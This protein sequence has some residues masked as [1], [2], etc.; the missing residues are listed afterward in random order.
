MNEVIK[1]EIAFDES[2]MMLSYLYCLDKN[3]KLYV[4]NNLYNY[5]HFDN[6]VPDINVKLNILN[7]IHLTILSL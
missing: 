5:R 3:K 4:S 2:I 1:C 6:Y 7:F